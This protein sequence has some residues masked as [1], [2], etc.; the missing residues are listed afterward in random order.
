MALDAVESKIDEYQRNIRL[1]RQRVRRQ[2]FQINSLN[3]LLNHLQSNNLLS[4][5]AMANIMVNIK[6]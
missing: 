5:S 6:K 4:N 3:D 1:L 2:Q